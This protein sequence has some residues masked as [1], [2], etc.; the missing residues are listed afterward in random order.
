MPEAREWIAR[1]GLERHPEGGFYRET[2][3]SPARMGEGDPRAVCTAIV[4]LLEGGDFSA[5]HRI[6][7]DEMWHFHDGAPLRLHLLG[8]QG[9][10]RTVLLGRDVSAGHLPQA[11]VPAGVWF[12]ATVEDPRSFSLVGCTVAPGFEFE[13][14]QIGDRNRLLLEYPEHRELIVRLTRC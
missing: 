14:L 7:S 12:G 1:L 4:Y 11:V 5:L 6:R 8:P 9:R 2:Y 10:Y 3:R 13:D